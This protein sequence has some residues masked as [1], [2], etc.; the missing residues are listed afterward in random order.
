MSAA[1]NSSRSVFSYWALVS[2]QTLVGGKLVSPHSPALDSD[3]DAQNG[4]GR[5]DRW[6]AE[7]MAALIDRLKAIP[8][9]TGSVFDST[10]IV[11]MNELSKGNSHDADNVPH[12]IAGSAQGFF[13]TGRYVR[14]ERIGDGRIQRPMGRWSNDLNVTLLRSM[15]ID[16][17][18]FGDPAEFSTPLDDLLSG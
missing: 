8:E 5:V 3:M 14:L 4:I 16:A 11:W 7:Q 12:L 18:S 13:K 6:N 1:G 9:G 17:Q 2:R 10:A 15:G